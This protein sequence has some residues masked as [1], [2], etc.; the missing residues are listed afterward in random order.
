MSL[1]GLPEAW[2]RNEVEGSESWPAGMFSLQGSLPDVPDNVY[3]WPGLFADTLPVYLNISHAFGQTGPVSYLHVDCDIY[4]GEAVV[5][6]P[7]L[8]QRIKVC[9][10]CSKLGVAGTKDVLQLL[11]DRLQ[12]GTVII[13]DDL[14]NYA[15]YRQGELKAMWEW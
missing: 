11:S 8:Q 12:V 5:S 6:A 4:T 2:K 15:A 7:E 1:T 14:V 10:E 3:L 13:F 9:Q